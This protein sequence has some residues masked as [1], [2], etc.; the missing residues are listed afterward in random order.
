[1]SALDS[2]LVTGGA[3]YIGSHVVI[4][5]REAGIPVVV[6][7]DLSTGWRSAIPHDV[8]L[9]VGD[10]GNRDLIVDIVRGRAVTAVMHFAGS[11]V[12][13]DSVARPLDYYA[14][15]TL[16]GHALIAACVQS[17]IRNFIYSS[18]AAVY[19]VPADLPVEESSDLRPINPYGSSKLMTEWFLRDVGVAQEFRYVTFRYFNVAGADPKG[20][21]GQSTAN[22][23]HLIK[24]ACEFAVGRR[25]GLT[26]FG[27]DYATPDGTC[28][29]DYL[30]VTDLAHA[31]IL[32]L[33]YLRAGGESLTLKCGYGRGFLVREVLAT[34]ERVG[35]CRLKTT[36]GP[37]RP[38]DPA[39]L[40]AGSDRIRETLNW[41]PRYDDLDVIVRTALAW[42][43]RLSESPNTT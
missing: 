11:I 6:V 13:S 15:N 40:V 33:M 16:K 14:N 27:D 1:M 41:R 42:E 18:T 4:A 36:L 20:R 5:L 39:A 37:R 2:V 17:G 35:Q 30:H 29:R 31:H 28:I 34:V 22:A 10:I 9:I 3:G 12:V 38:G 19:G 32:A 24:V 21:A 25:P 8:P 7:D 26:I 23:T 43:R